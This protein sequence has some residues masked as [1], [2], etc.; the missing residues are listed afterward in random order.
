MGETYSRYRQI[1]QMLKTMYPEEPRGHVAIRLNTLVA[2]ICGII[3]SRHTRLPAIA[4]EIPS[5]CQEH[6]QIQKLKRWLINEHVDAE[7]YFL[8]FLRLVLASLAHQ[9]LVLVIDGS[10]VGRGCVTLMLSVRYRGRA[11]P[12]MWVVKTGKK[13]HFPESLHIELINSV[14]SLI[15]EGSDVVCLGDGEFDGVEFL[16]TMEQLGWKY[17]CRTAKNAVVFEHGERFAI[18]DVCPAL[19]HRVELTGV[20]FTEAAYGPIQAVAWWEK[21]YQ[22]PIYLVTNLPL[23]EEACYWYRLRFR[24]ETFFSDQKSR[25]FHLHKSHLSDPQRLAR[26]M[27]ATC[28][29]YLWIVFLGVF[30]QDTPWVRRLLHRTDRCD[31]SLFQLGL[32]LLKRFLREGLALPTFRFAMPE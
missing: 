10:V 11:L 23:A 3:G 13:G 9:T 28:L 7:T 30:A 32:R 14:K 25:G 19:G 27:I 15:P 31:L 4:G 1:W 21:G 18:Q 16:A 29:A 6:S 24:I 20:H 8:P 12:L 17:V 5:A 26:L 2:F 22:D